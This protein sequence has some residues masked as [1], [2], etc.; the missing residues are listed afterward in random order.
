MSL[1][2]DRIASPVGTLA[3]V[4]DGAALCALVFEDHEA[5]LSRHLAQHYRDRAVT[6]ARD[7]GGFSSKLA[8]YFDGALDAIDDIPVHLEGSSF[9]RAVWTALREIPVGSTTTYG[10]LAQKLG[11]PPGASRA[12]GLAN[13]ANPVAIVVPCHRVIGAKDRLVGYGGGLARKQ[14]LLAHERVELALTPA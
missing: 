12:V 13:G 3:V 2:L 6:P 14:W 10:A 9:Q 5:W 11:K 8:A 4:S 1:L 7:P